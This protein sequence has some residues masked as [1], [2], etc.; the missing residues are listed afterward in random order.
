LL[1]YLQRLQREGK[2]LTAPQTQALERILQSKFPDADLSKLVQSNRD[3]QEEVAFKWN[4]NASDDD[5]SDDDDDGT[6]KKT[7]KLEARPARLGLGA[8]HVVHRTVVGESEEALAKKLSKTE[9]RRLRREEEEREL[10]QEEE[11][12]KQGATDQDQDSRSGMLSSRSKHKEQRT[13]Q[14]ADKAEE[15]LQRKKDKKARKKLAKQLKKQKQQQEQKARQEHL[16]EQPQETKG[17]G[18]QEEQGEVITRVSVAQAAAQE[19]AAMKQMLKEQLKQHEEKEH[20]STGDKDRVDPS[21]Q[22]RVAT[23][24]KL[25]GYK[26]RKKTRS[27]Q[28][29]I[30]K[31]TR[32]ADHKPTFLTPGSIDY[33][34]NAPRSS[35]K[36]GPTIAI[37]RSGDGGGD[38]GGAG[39][40]ADGGSSTKEK[41]QKK[42]KKKKGVSG[43][44]AVS[45]GGAQKRKANT[46]AE[47]KKKQAKKQKKKNK[48]IVVGKSVRAS[49][50][51]EPV[52]KDA[53]W[54]KLSSKQP[55]VVMSNNAFFNSGQYQSWD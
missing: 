13:Q 30:K 10:L 39:D 27:R 21:S 12:R 9:K 11:Q 26:K 25:T 36:R 16:P 54:K 50:V 1:A 40:G 51:K 28:K 17:A 44:S 31:D 48:T 37:D 19:K 2:S 41:K 14:E 7:V 18:G 8:T 55:K 46:F 3:P 38:G 24:K 15:Q 23:K 52:A 20:R 34:P 6:A 5:S 35:A 49:R 42:K 45:G 53:E 32:G 43:V 4:A 29:N 47:L 22:Q 33:N